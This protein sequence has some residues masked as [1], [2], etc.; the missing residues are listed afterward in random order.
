MKKKPMIVSL[1]G[2]LLLLVVAVGSFGFQSLTTAHHAHA[3]GNGPSGSQTASGEDY[4]DCTILHDN[5][6]SWNL[7]CPSYPN[8]TVFGVQYPLDRAC[9]ASNEIDNVVKAGQPNNPPTVNNPPLAGSCYPTGGQ[10]DSGN[11]TVSF[12]SVATQRFVTVNPN[13]PTNLTVTA[14]GIGPGE[15]FQIEKTGGSG[16]IHTLDLIKF[17]AFWGA[18]DKRFVGP[19]G[20]AV[21]GMYANRQDQD[22]WENFTINRVA[23]SSPLHFGDIVTLQAKDGRY[24][25][26]DPTGGLYARSTTIGP[27]E[28][29]TMDAGVCKANLQQY[30]L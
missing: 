21:G 6:T 15:S 4:S 23:G 30:G 24:L 8:C 22:P 27:N 25:S 19:D 13:E 16:Y 9:G 26:V 14:A 2:V 3:A 11:T 5:G 20:T 18:S 17:Q 10:V 1:A 28:E 7:A 29:F 12:L